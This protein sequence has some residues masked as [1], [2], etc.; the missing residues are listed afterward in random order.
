[1]INISFTEEQAKYLSDYFENMKDK[2]KLQY[3]IY[4]KIHD[5]YFLYGFEKWKK[6]KREENNNDHKKTS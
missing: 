4:A 6:Q 1:M 3:E 5:K 2:N